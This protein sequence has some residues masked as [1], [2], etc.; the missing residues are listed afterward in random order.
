MDA[1]RALHQ[2][3]DREVGGEEGGKDGGGGVVHNVVLVRHNVGDQRAA[4]ADQQ[5]GRPVH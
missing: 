4:D 5:D 1:K 3:P 2:K